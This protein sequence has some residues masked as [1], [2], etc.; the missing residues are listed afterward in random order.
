MSHFICVGIGW[1]ALHFVIKH[2]GLRLPSDDVEALGSV[3]CSLW[4]WQDHKST[5][6]HARLQRTNAAR[7]DGCRVCA[8]HEVMEHR[9]RGRQEVTM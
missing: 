9:D 6:I 4:S 3:P 1:Y 8:G 7:R 5:C 2:S